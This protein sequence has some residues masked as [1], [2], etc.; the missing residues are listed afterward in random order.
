M[1]KRE[2]RNKRYNYKRGRGYNSLARIFYFLFNNTLAK[3][4]HK[5]KFKYK[6]DV[7]LYNKTKKQLYSYDFLVVEDE[8]NSD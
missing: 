2:G 1:G 8:K 7:L 3:T 4:G 6:K 5:I